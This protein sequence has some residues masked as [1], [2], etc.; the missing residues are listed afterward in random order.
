MGFPLYS[1]VKNPPTVQR[2]KRNFGVGREDPAKEMTTHQYFLWEIPWT[3]ELKVAVHEA[4]RVR[5][6]LAIK[7][8]K[9]QFYKLLH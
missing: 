6:N 3:E 8:Q 7:Q 5:D 2:H 1:V 9:Q 4:P